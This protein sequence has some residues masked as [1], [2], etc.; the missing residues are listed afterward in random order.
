MTQHDDNGNEPTGLEIAIVGMA[1][2]VPGANDTEQYWNNLCEG[3]ESLTHL[4][5]EH[6]EGLGIEPAM[7]DH[8]SYVKVARRVEDIDLWDAAFFGSSP[9]E[10]EILDPQIRLFLESCWQALEDAGYD[11]E[12]AGGLIGC[13]GGSKLSTYMIGLYSNPDVME[14]MGEFQVQIGNDKDYVATRVAYKM[15]LGGP[16]VTVQTACSTSLVATHLACQA[17]LSGECDLALAGGVS[18]FAEDMGYPYREGEIYSKD[19]HI[20]AFDADAT[21]TIFGNGLG[22]VVLKRLEDALEDGDTIRAVIKGT[23]INNDSNLKVG[24]SAPGAD[25]QARVIRA[26]QT[27]AEVDPST[28]TYVE[29]HG[30]GTSTG[31]PI[32]VSALTRAF[33]E[34]TEETQFCALGA[35][36][37]N[38]GHLGAAAGIAGLIKATL[39]L[40]NKQLPPSINFERP[41]PQ[42][43]FAS[44]PFYV[45]TELRDWQVPEGQPRRAGM[46]AFGIGGTNA[47]AVLEE[48]PVASPSGSSRRLQLLCLSAR[49]PEAVDVAGENLANHLEAHPEQPLADVAHTLHRGRRA[50]EVRRVVVAADHADAVEALRDP[51]RQLTETYDG[52]QRPVAFLFTGQGSQYPNMGKG[53]YESEPV[54]RDT[55]D[56]CC[57][58]LKEHLGRDLRDLIYPSEEE[59]E[60][61]KEVLQETRYTQPALFVIETATAELWKSW[62]LVPD[63]MIGHSIGEYAAACQAGVFSVEAGLALVAARGQLMQDLPPGDMLSVPLSEEDI[64]PHLGAQLSI[65]ALNAPGRSVVSGPSEAIQE[66]AKKLKGERVRCS[67]LHTSHAFHSGMMEPIL[68]PFIDVVSKVDL[69]APTTPYVSNVTGRWITEAEAT[70]PSYYAVHLRQAVRFAD[71]VAKLFEEPNRLFVEVGPG[72][73]LTTLSR[74]HPDKG[75]DHRLVSSIRHPKAKVADDLA[76]ALDAVGQVWMAG[77]AL[78]W[79]AFYGDEDRRRVPLPTYPF[80]RRRYWIQRNLDGGFG[81]APGARA[82]TDL[83]EWFE[84]PHWKPSAPPAV[85]EALGVDADPEDWLLF[86]DGDAGVGAAMADRLRALG[87]SVTTV[88][89]GNAFTD[90]GGGAYTLAP[91]S[92]D[93]HEA[94]VTAL[95]EAE[96]LPQRVV[97]LWSVGTSENTDSEVAAG[98]YSLL[99]LAQC[100]GRRPAK[101][102]IHLLAVS[103]DAVRLGFDGADTRR[104]AKATLL[105]PVLVAGREVPV[106]RTAAVDVTLAGG[107][108]A[109]AAIDALIAEADQIAEGEVLAHRSGDRWLRGYEPVTVDSV[110]EGT[111]RMRDEGVVLITGGLGG[112]GLT[113]ADDLAR[114]HRAKL[115]L[116]SRSGLPDRD[117]WDSVLAEA[118]DGDRTAR[119]I[120]Q[121]RGLEAHGAEVLVMAAD[122]TR[123]EDMARVVAASEERFGGLHG[124]IHAAGIAGAG[125]LQLKTEEMAAGVLAPKVAGTLALAEALGDR[126]LDYFLLCSSTIAVLGTFGQVD[127]CAANNFLDAFAE[128]R[129][130]HPSRTLSVNFG[131]WQDVGMAVETASPGLTTQSDTATE[132]TPEPTSDDSGPSEEPPTSIAPAA[133]GDGIHP[134]LDRRVRSEHS[135]GDQGDAVY[136]TEFDPDRH[137]VLDE[138][139]IMGTPAIPGTT[140]LELARAAYAAHSGDDRGAEVGDVFFFQPL[141]V[142]RGETQEGRVVLSAAEGGGFDFRFVSP[143]GADGG[144]TDHTRGK[145]G[146]LPADAEARQVDLDAI[147]TRCDRVVEVE[148]DAK[149]LEE[150]FVYWGARWN[151]LERIHHGENEGLAQLTLPEAFEGDLAGMVLHPALVDVATALT[152]ALTEGDNYLPLSYHRVRVFG[153]LPRRV[154]SHLRLTS[155]STTSETV[156]ADVSLLDESGRELVSIERFSMK[157]V[158]AGREKL[159]EAGDGKTDPGLF[160]AG[161]MKPAQGVEALRRILSRLD[162]PRVIVSQRSIEKLREQLSANAPTLEG[163]DS[164]AATSTAQGTSHPRPNLPTPYVAPSKPTEE[165]LAG[166]WQNVLGLD[167]VGVHDNFF[168]LGGDSVLGMTV[169]SQASEAGLELIPEYLFNHQTVAELAEVLD[170][171]GS[172]EGEA[173]V[174]DGEDDLSADELSE[175]LA[176]LDDL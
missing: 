38:I 46:S 40:E 126:P 168:D 48:A 90:L 155:G 137:W 56:R 55:V 165:T 52:R 107:P 30:T 88:T 139:R 92:K 140:Y 76:F 13:Y 78:D 147:K 110:A 3:V 17:L 24:Y 151:S 158:G 118:A 18:L 95:A 116:V 149:A 83:G 96:A 77:A 86:V 35:V 143:A 61:A 153:A 129:V 22:V 144:W 57:E 154:L 58:V 15:A 41:N 162:K 21:G 104:P 33:R 109:D 9:R 132:S 12:N 26:A 84:L 8:P 161:G 101:T 43:D 74:R 97:H 73:T 1:I 32:E 135:D 72:N 114:R 75:E 94:L 7:Y 71:G 47:H 115:V 4:D 80:E 70:D 142:P 51:K 176:Q 122:V 66:L 100:L 98:F 93:G 172:S 82:R 6:F 166:I 112:F 119:Q 124:V 174:S 68:Q 5:A 157:R 134:L 91:G 103:S 62:G 105:G 89:R 2:R 175:V 146:P 130:G 85:P 59:A 45:N 123:A 67:A 11:S 150:K 106:L 44:S 167:K 79:K 36:K 148:R 65:A 128:A 42:I 170:A 23:A 164:A 127:Y 169:I 34:T 20:R 108:L 27:V 163:A 31:D 171:A 145:V 99:W 141:M 64:L 54:F 81:A 63:A 117:T 113:F 37:S 152:A 125:L 136:A 133:A 53:L 121:V 173:E 25:G 87:R 50:F 160:A 39:C 159:A 49:S 60:A 69:Q 16:A 14:R 102:P 19:G 111:L 131:A 29:T 138:H 120:R 156:S 10:A 28:I